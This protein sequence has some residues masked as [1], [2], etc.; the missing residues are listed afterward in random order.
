MDAS[1]LLDRRSLMTVV[2]TV[3]LGLVYPLVVTG[4]AQVLF[5][6]QANG[7]LVERNGQLIGLADHRP[8]VHVARILLLAAVGGRRRLRRGRLVRFESRADEQEADRSCGGDV[9]RLQ[10][11]E[12]GC[13]G[14]D[15]SGD[16]LGFRTGSA[17]QPGRGT[18]SSSARGARAGARRSGACGRSSSSTPRPSV[19]PSGRAASS[20]CSC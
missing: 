11:R 19:R 12:S 13:A 16:D 2:T 1:I 9:A 18:V 7:Q 3:L 15:R 4:L 5:P 17:H 8:A 14:S 10:A 20:M 6:D